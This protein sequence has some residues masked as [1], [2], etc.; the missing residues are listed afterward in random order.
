MT[1]SPGTSP[2][3]DSKAVPLP[4]CRTYAVVV[5]YNP[6]LSNLEKLVAALQPQVEA[7]LLVDNGSEERVV[8]WMQSLRDPGIE[9]ILN[10]ANLGVAAAQNV[11]IRRAIARGASHVAIFDHDSLPAENTIGQLLAAEHKVL[12]EN[13]DVRVAA[14]GPA[15]IDTKTD[16]VSPFIRINGW[17]IRRQLP[18]MDQVWIQADYLISSGT[19]LPVGALEEIGLMDEGLFIDYIDIE[20]GLRAR[21]KGFTCIGVP[22]ARMLHTI[23][24]GVVKL[25]FT[26]RYVNLHSSKRHYFLYRN[27]LW[28]YRRSYVPFSW[29]IQDAVRMFVKIPLYV[30][31]SADKIEELR[32]IFRGVGSGLSRRAKPVLPGRAPVSRLP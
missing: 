20:W 32:C 3:E 7:V 16:K 27:A 17:R 25:P 15:F 18:R 19:L 24:E 4:A 2:E 22:A 30:A 12:R 1:K 5:C 10:G 21:A 13:R 28:L 29:K 14:I 31:K 6:V 11:G 23:G 8:N 9:V 26:G